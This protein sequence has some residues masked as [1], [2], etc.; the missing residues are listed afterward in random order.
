MYEFTDYSSKKYQN[1]LSVDFVFNGD[2]TSEEAIE[3]IEL[4]VKLADNNEE[5]SFIGWK[6]SMYMKTNLE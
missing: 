1:E 3:Q 4:L 5:I 2:I 6:P